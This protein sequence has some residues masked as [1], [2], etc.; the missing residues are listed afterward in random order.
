MSEPDFTNIDPT[1]RTLRAV[2]WIITDRHGDAASVREECL[3]AV[4]HLTDRYGKR[5]TPAALQAVVE[6]FLEGQA[7]FRPVPD[8]LR[9]CLLEIAQ[10]YQDRFITVGSLGRLRNEMWRVT[11][12]TT[13]SAIDHAGQDWRRIAAA[14]AVPAA[15]YPEADQPVIQ[16]LAGNQPVADRHL[17]E[18]PSSIG[19]ATIRHGHQLTLP[20]NGKSAWTIGTANLSEDQVGAII[21][22]WVNGGRY[23]SL[24]GTAKGPNPVRELWDRSL[25][26]CAARKGSDPQGDSRTARFVMLR[27]PAPPA[28]FLERL[29]ACL[30]PATLATP[31]DPGQPD[32]RNWSDSFVR[33]AAAVAADCCGLDKIPTLELELAIRQNLLFLNGRTVDEGWLADVATIAWKHCCDRVGSATLRRRLEAGPG[34]QGPGK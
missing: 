11:L 32:D 24:T 33:L 17:K 19:Y 10:I 23:P 5:L 27:C 7:A 4:K 22:S 18:E 12:H 30:P 9:P 29:R 25:V 21:Q 20:K 8:Q 28:S 1:T 31:G 13:G 34:E 16:D 3:Q 2:N 6:T 14:A 15:D 26:K